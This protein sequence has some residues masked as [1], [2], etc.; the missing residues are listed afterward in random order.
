MTNK[1]AGRSIFVFAAE[2]N[3]VIKTLQGR[4]QNCANLG[5]LLAHLGTAAIPSR[6]LTGT[7]WCNF[8]QLV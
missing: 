7:Q 6:Q 2:Q 8:A 4:I 1:D 5:S 3:L